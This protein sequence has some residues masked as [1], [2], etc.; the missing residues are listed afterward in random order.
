ML[1]AWVWNDCSRCVPESLDAA[2]RSQEHIYTRRL[3]SCRTWQSTSF[4]PGG[5]WGIVMQPCF[6]G[7]H[8]NRPKPGD[9]LAAFKIRV[10]YTWLLTSSANRHLFS[11]L[12]FSITCTC[13]SLVAWACLYRSYNHSNRYLWYI[14]KLLL[15]IL[16][17]CFVCSLWRDKVLGH[18]YLQRCNSKFFFFVCALGDMCITLRL[19]LLGGLHCVPI[20]FGL[21]ILKM[22][23]NLYKSMFQ[24]QLFFCYI[25]QCV[26]CGLLLVRLIS[27]CPTN[28]LS[29]IFSL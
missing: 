3:F 15:Y 17:H 6:V 24:T 1:G 19:L 14:V 11:L 12:W 10:H 13:Q 2:A 23:P 21:K 18:L 4:R 26:Y 9:F 8:C 25:L 29:F 28:K 16:L 20:V 27:K 22:S 5:S 7:N